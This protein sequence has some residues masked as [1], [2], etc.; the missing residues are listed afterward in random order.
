[1]H[2]RK[3]SRVQVNRIAVRRKLWRDLLLNLLQSIVCVRTRDAE[4]RRSHAAKHRTRALQRSDR[5]LKRRCVACTRNRMHLGPLLRHRARKR[6]RVVL[7]LDAIEVRCAE[8][9]GARLKQR[10]CG[11]SY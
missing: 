6:L 10:I 7:I 5:I 2:P 9:Q 3:Q 8:W 11:E 4:E 1:M